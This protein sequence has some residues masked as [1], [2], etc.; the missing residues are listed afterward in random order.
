[1]RSLLI[2]NYD[3]FTYNLY[4]LIS[5]VT[6]Q[7][8]VVVRNDADWR[9][10]R[11]SE[12]DAV[13]ISP[14][15]GR[16]E[17]QRDFGVSSRVIVESGLPVL[18]VCLGHQGVCHLFG[19]GIVSAPEP[20]HG[21]VSA[22][23]HS[24]VDIFAGLPSPFD[25]VRYHSLAAADLPEELEAI[26]WTDDGVVMGVR[27]RSEPIWGVQFHPESIS[28]TYGH[29]LV[30]NFRDLALQQRRSPYRVHVRK[31]ADC[32]DTEAA[33]RALFAGQQ[34]SFW[35]DSSSVIEGFSRFSFM[36]GCGP[37]GEY[38]T[39]RVP[40][41]VV[42]VHRPGRDETAGEAVEQE[43]AE[44]RVEQG[45]FSYLEDQLQQRAVPKPE[46]LPFD[47]NLGYVGYLGYELKAESG[48]QAVHKA[49]T[50]D[51]A[52]LF[53]DRMLAVDHVEGTCYLLTLSRG[54]ATEPLAWLE[55]ARARL[56][57]VTE[58][59]PAPP[60]HTTFTGTGMTD[61]AS[62]ELVELRHDRQGY[63]NRIAES[64][65]LIRQGESY[66]ICL[67]NAVTVRTPIVALDTYALLRRISPVPYG[68]LLDFPEVAVLSASPERFLTMGT[69]RVFESKPIKGTRPRGATPE[70]DEE[71]RQDLLTR[72][73]DRSENLMI[74]DLLRNDLNRVGEVG[75]VHVPR[76]FHVE[77]YATVHQLVS[78]IR[79][80][81]RAEE[82]AVGCVRAAFPGGSM[83][84][85]PKIRTMEI[86]D[87][88]EEG[89][90]GVYS[91]ALGWFS[92]SGAMDL[93]IVIRTLVAHGDRVSFGVGGAIVALS[94]PEEEFEETT[95]KSRAMVSAVLAT[96]TPPTPARPE[97][98]SG[99]APS[100]SGS[101]ASRLTPAGG[102]T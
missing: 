28:S 77:T 50:P 10:L 68:A 11:L 21:R 47:F 14:G 88:L 78:T 70:E 76:L 87:Q 36:G 38:V 102:S 64:L 53:T 84:G 18:G 94:D 93:S 97:V 92:L 56:A 57:H 96:A 74:V 16:P 100:P 26:A 91:G 73:K 72:E 44:E 79:G 48:G 19:G 55:Q 42:T 2:D 13:V 34:H 61:P 59:T 1:M 25:T 52:L 33:Y 7:P 39:Y 63:L 8:P 46:G 98:T 15:P 89:P 54:D 29:D 30:A 49:E 32:P 17:R 90:R 6:E 12:F 99:E 85:A 20:M 60:E 22:V 81:L 95:V 41:G 31:L 43:P 23:H 3:S 65:E 45:F 27:H 67:T 37:L 35:L 83:T 69:D 86:I 80:T 101:A 75:S 82:S 5:E 9:E 66:E 40:E 24:G 71:L 58:P 62:A 51:A 4:Q